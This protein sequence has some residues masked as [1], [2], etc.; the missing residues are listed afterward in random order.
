M[1]G[2]EGELIQR[3]VMQKAGATCPVKRLW[4]SSLTEEAIRAGFA[5]LKDQADYQPLY[6]AGL[7]R[8]IGDW[9]LG[10]NATRLYT[11]KFGRQER[12]AQPLSVGRVQTPRSPHRAPATG[13]RAIPPRT[14]LGA[15]DASTARPRSRRRRAVLPARTRDAR[16][17][18]APPRPTSR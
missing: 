3:W 4:I 18:S 14:L 2:Q 12:G 7:A 11:L 6:E 15:H 9:L 16:P 1:P 17:W 8:A 5:A 13:D 10:M